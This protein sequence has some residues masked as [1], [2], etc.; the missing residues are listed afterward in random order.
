M[1]QDTTFPDDPS[2]GTLFDQVQAD[3]S[4]TSKAT[5]GQDVA[6]VEGDSVLQRRTSRSQRRR[7]P[8]AAKTTM[9]AGDALEMRLAR[10]HFWQGAFTRRG[11]N[12]QKHFHPDPLLVTDLDLLAIEFSA[13]LTIVKT[14]GE[15][16][17]GT[18]R[19]TPKPLDRS[20]WIAGLKKLIGADRGLVM[21]ATRSSQR[22]RET[23]MTLGVVSLTVEDLDRWEELHLRESL[24][25]V[26]PHGPGAFASDAHAQA[27]VKG[28]P[29][30]ERA[31]W[32]VK[33]EAWFLD[34]WQA[35]KRSI[36]ALGQLSRFWSAEIDDEQTAALRWL[37]AELLSLLTMNLVA[38]V[39]VFQASDKQSWPGYVREKMAQGAIAIQNQR[40][41]ADAFDVYM[42]RVLREIDAPSTI[43]VEAMGAFHPTPPQWT[44][45]LIELLGRLE[46]DSDLR[47]FARN[48]DFI[49]A[50]RLVRRRH[51]SD[52]AI[53]AMSTRD[54][55]EFAKLR[56]QVAAFLRGSVEVPDVI[57]RAMTT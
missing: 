9:S 40:A 16:K 19:N 55:E 30:L 21:T 44:Q 38:L 28:E 11:V 34:P 18:S 26:G 57:D 10:M 3:D 31:Y 46:T 51:A 22:V 41:L 17:S 1:S 7:L 32:F 37:Y 48:T 27:T 23:M 43:Q 56:R 14:I 47:D 33:S 39:G 8:A 36:G 4:P 25:D 2:D 49:L 15:A 50:E 29:T 5:G 24:H 12:L 6:P 45:P 13:R 54:P 53:K 52:E 42:A 35:T 20:I